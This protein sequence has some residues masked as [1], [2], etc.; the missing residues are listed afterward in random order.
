MKDKG[1]QLSSESEHEIERCGKAKESAPRRLKSVDISDYKLFEEEQRT[2]QIVYSYK[3]GKKVP[4]LREPRSLFAF[5]E[6]KK[7]QPPR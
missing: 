3:G 4:K 7:L 6:E 1:V 5:N 2:T